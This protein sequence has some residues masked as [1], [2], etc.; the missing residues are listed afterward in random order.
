MM[1]NERRCVLFSSK[2]DLSKRSLTTTPYISLYSVGKSLQRARSL[3][4]R[5]AVDATK[6]SD[7]EDE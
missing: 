1:A 3:P 7:E 4:S 6:Q 2:L 5:R